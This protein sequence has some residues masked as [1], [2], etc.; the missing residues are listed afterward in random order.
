ME[1]RTQQSWPPSGQKE[2][3]NV[4]KTEWHLTLVQ[5]MDGVNLKKDSLQT[6]GFR[7]YTSKNEV[8]PLIAKHMNNE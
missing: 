1:S 8:G 2:P 7:A 3:P 5:I 4:Q 6:K